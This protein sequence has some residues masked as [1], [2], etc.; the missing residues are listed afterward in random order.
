MIYNITDPF[1]VSFVDYVNTRDFAV[2]VCDDT[3]GDGSI[4]NPAV[5]DLGPEVI[6]FIAADDSPTGKPLLAVANE[7]SGTTSV[8]EIV[9]D[10]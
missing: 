9:K 4:P 7:I 1:D 2:P 10:R 6:H 3:D 5:G 8:F